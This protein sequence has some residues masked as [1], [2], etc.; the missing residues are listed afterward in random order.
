MM[1]SF[2]QLPR[3]DKSVSEPYCKAVMTAY[4]EV[5]TAYKQV[6]HLL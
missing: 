1:Q 3:N 6:E 5:T 4:K 2:G